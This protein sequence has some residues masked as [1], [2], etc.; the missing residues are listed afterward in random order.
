MSLH[1]DRETKTVTKA[2]E[3]ELQRQ[4]SIQ[5][6]GRC[7]KQGRQRENRSFRSVAPRF[8]AFVDQENKNQKYGGGD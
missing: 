4:L 6:T 2:T 8:G 1:V 3:G 5:R 7:E